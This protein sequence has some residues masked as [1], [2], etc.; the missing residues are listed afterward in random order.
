MLKNSLNSIPGSGH[1][2]L[3]TFNQFF[4]VKLYWWADQKF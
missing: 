1:R 2:R 3:T 4:L